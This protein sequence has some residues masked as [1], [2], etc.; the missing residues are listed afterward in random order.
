[1]ATRHTRSTSFYVSLPLREFR[2][3]CNKIRYYNSAIYDVIPLV[4][5]ELNFICDDDGT[6]IGDW[7]I[8]PNPD[9]DKQDT[10]QYTSGEIPEMI[11]KIAE[12]VDFNE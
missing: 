7:W 2:N 5:N 10:K 11:H 1:M 4:D 3:I 8:V 9:P 12:G 6:F